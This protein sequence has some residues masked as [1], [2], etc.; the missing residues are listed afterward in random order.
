MP[1]PANAVSPMAATSSA[2]EAVGKVTAREV[3][4]AEGSGADVPQPDHAV[5]R[6]GGRPDQRG[7]EQ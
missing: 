3:D 7:P 5:R 2:S 6:Q 1:S 4:K